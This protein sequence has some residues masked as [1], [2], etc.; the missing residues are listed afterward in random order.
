MDNIIQFP[1]IETSSKQELETIIAQNFAEHDV[2]PD[3]VKALLERMNA[4][5]DIICDSKI[6]LSISSNPSKE[7]LENLFN[8]IRENISQFTN[9]LLFE[10][11]NAEIFYMKGD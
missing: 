5:L 3:D 2:H 4:F 9:Q 6:S 8:S 1:K 11:I 10:R 7:D